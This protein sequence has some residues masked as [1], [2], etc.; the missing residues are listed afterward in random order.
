MCDA[1]GHA[2]QVWS[3]AFVTVRRM[4]PRSSL[5]GSDPEFAA[6]HRYSRL[7]VEV[8]TH[9]FA[10]QR[11][12]EVGTTKLASEPLR[13]SWFDPGYVR[14]VGGLKGVSPAG[15]LKTTPSFIAV[16]KKNCGK[17][18]GARGLQDFANLNRIVCGGLNP[19]SVYRCG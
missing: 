7:Q 1:C 3:A 6:H 10:I 14:P 16:K 17:P 2:R 8:A 18:Q 13:V 12:L 11:S 15:L 5:D 4:P 19:M 9:N